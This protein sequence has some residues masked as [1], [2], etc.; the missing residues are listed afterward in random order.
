MS[1]TR[2]DRVVSIALS[3]VIR[4]A[5]LAAL[6]WG[7][8]HYRQSTPIAQTLAIEGT[9]VSNATPAPPQPAAAETG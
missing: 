4:A 7:F 3:V 6:V 9:V 2:T 5:I 8:W 1:E